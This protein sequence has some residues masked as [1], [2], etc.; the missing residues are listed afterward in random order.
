MTNDLNESQIQRLQTATA[1]IA[2]TLLQPDVAYRLRTAPGQ[3]EWSAM[4][5]MGHVTEM[6]P[7]WLHH[8]KVI[9]DS[10]TPHTFGRGYDDPERLAGVE[11]GSVGDPN[12]IV[13]LLNLQVADI[14]AFIGTLTPEQRAKTGNN[15]TRGVMSVDDI[16]EKNMVAHA[17]AHLEQ[18][19]TA[20]NA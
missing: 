9:I 17:E 20:L 11:R 8:S 18:V 6:L 10:T 19:R 7:Y 3:N 16:V 12:E 4:Q 14:V 15:V 1:K 2:E 5:V 13:R